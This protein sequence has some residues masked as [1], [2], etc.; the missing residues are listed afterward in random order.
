MKTFLRSSTQNVSMKVIL[1]DAIGTLIINGV[2]N[3]PLFALLET[4]PYK[5]IILTNAN[6]E[7]IVTYKLTN[8][9][10]ELFTLKHAPNK[11]DPEYFKHFLKKY[12]LNAHDC[13]YIE[14]S[15]HAVQSA[16]SIGIP[17]HQYTQ[18]L[19]LLRQFLDDAL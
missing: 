17:T 18:D 2:I 7:E 12:A 11:D 6:D 19:E 16:R 9:P 15:V 5:K 1:V 3:T 10:Y 8:V 13:A 14:H 4:Y